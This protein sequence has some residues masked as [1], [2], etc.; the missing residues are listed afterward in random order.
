MT[1]RRFVDMLLA[2]QFLALA[3][4]IVYPVIAYLFPGAAA[5]AEPVE[6]AL[7]PAGDLAPGTARIVKMGARPVLVLRTPEGQV[8]A[9]SAKCTHLNC[10]VQYR[11]EQSS[12]WCAC[13]D[14]MYD[15]EGR[16]V[17][18]PP[19][20]PL[21]PLTVELREGELYLKKA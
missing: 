7:G 5:E 12:I 3:A 2:G 11:K 6:L 21:D 13:H 1:R 18:G 15:L 17:S 9:M 16:N 20:R 19:P 14:G 8:R 4:A 10:T